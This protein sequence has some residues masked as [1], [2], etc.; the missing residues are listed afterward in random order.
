MRAI[1]LSA[2]I[3]GAAVALAGCGSKDAG[4][5]TGGSTSATATSTSKAASTGSAKADSSS[6]A[7][8]G[9]KKEKKKASKRPADAKKTVEKSTDESA[10]KKPVPKD[11]KKGEKKT[12]DEAKEKKI[13][14]KAD[15]AVEGACTGVPDDTAECVIN[16][17]Y[18]CEGGE[19]YYFDCD[20]DARMRGFI[21]GA[22][23]QTEQGVDCF[24]ATPSEDPTP[25]YSVY[26]DPYTNICTDSNGYQWVDPNAGDDMPAPE[27]PAD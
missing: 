11:A 20:E 13:E 24:D 15:N 19:L 23:M 16:K 1:A 8:A 27:A 5:T 14:K 9:D 3:A 17:L 7:K 2:W 26:C 4:S 10:L 21:G 18:F 12:I 22:C 25:D 6:A